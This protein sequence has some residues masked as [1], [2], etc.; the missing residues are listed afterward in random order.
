M[1]DNALA[2]GMVT[3]RETDAVINAYN[4]ALDGRSAGTNPDYYY[5]Q[6]TIDELRALGKLRPGA[7][8]HRRN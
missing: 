3:A 7:A 2:D 8:A 1:I 5:A 6:D 4:E